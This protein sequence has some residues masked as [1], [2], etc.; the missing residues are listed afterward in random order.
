MHTIK[1]FSP[2]EHTAAAGNFSIGDMSF[3]SL[4]N[5]SWN[6][7]DLTGELESAG[8]LSFLPTSYKEPS[9]NSEGPCW[10]INPISRS[11]R[12]VISSR[13]SCFEFSVQTEFVFTDKLLSWKLSMPWLVSATSSRSSSC[14]EFSEQTEFAFTDWLLSWKLSMSWLVSATGPYMHMCMH[15]EQKYRLTLCNLPDVREIS[16]A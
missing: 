12:G 2:L 5:T 8:S 13:S 16:I 9:K 14:F 15:M 1:S 4:K 3:L 7:P 6:P 11:S 10:S